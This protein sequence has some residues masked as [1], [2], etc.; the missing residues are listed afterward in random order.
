MFSIIQALFVFL[1]A[2]LYTHWGVAAAAAILWVVIVI[3]LGHL[4]NTSHQYRKP[5]WITLSIINFLG[6]VLVLGGIYLLANA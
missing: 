1:I 6:W 5:I 3:G 2:R 4:H